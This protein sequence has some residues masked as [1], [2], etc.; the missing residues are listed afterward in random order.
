MGGAFKS[1]AVS[2]ACHLTSICSTLALG[3]HQPAQGTPGPG[4]SGHEDADQDDHANRNRVG[5]VVAVCTQQRNV[6]AAAAAAN[7][8]QLELKRHQMTRSQ[9]HADCN[10]AIMLVTGAWKQAAT[11]N[12]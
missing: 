6:S 5:Q 12:S 7:V 10:T 2:I 8:M 4:E 1:K 11:T 9:A 3:T